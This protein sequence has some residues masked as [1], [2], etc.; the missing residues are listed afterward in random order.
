MRY[1]FGF[2]LLGILTPVFFVSAAEPI[3]KYGW[4][5]QATSY[6]E[7]AGPTCAEGLIK[8][9]F[10]LYDILSMNHISVA[11]VSVIAFNIETQATV[12][13]VTGTGPVTESV[14]YNP[15]TD[16]IA[17]YVEGGSDYFNFYS[18]KKWSEPGS[19]PRWG[20]ITS[21]VYLMPTSAPTPEYAQVSPVDTATSINPEYK[22]E[23][24][25]I[26]NLFG[27]T[28]FSDVFFFLNKYD[29]ADGSL[30]NIVQRHYAKDSGIGIMTIPSQTLSEGWYRWS[31]YLSLNAL[32]HFVPGLTMV[33]QPVSGWSTN[34]WPFLYDTT[35][36]EVQ[37]I[38]HTPAAVY[39][40]EQVQ[41]TGETSDALAG[42]KE[43]RMYFDGVFAQSCGYAS[44]Q[45]AQCQ[46]NVGPFPVGTTHSY[47]LV[48]TDGV[49]L[50]STS[51]VGTFT[52]L[53]RLLPN[54]LTTSVAPANG[55]S[56]SDS[57]PSIVFSGI[58]ESTN[59]RFA[60][61]GGWADLE[62]DWNSDGGIK[63]TGGDTFDANFNAFNGLMLGGFAFHEQKIL[64]YEVFNPPVGTHRYRFTA[65][66]T[67]QLPES[68]ENDNHS[69]WRT[70]I[71]EDSPNE[72]V[73]IPLTSA[74]SCSDVLPDDPIP[75]Q[76]INNCDDWTEPSMCIFEC[77]DG[78][79]KNVD[80][81]ELTECNDDID[82]TDAEDNHVD[83]EDVGCVDINDNDESDSLPVIT[84][85]VST[86][87]SV[88][89]VNAGDEV[90]LLWDTNNGDESLC[91]LVGPGID[92]DGVL[93]SEGDPETGSILV[94]IYGLSTYTL[95]CGGLSSQLKIEIA[96]KGW[97]S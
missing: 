66:V 58:A 3:G 17:I 13:T 51:T 88:S 83:M 16:G 52:V 80:V 35:P 14:C 86:L 24:T 27:A 10:E 20:L 97:N 37:S 63:G 15:D 79:V 46:L 89:V 84:S 29:P 59:V 49:G 77:M 7:L 40:T 92:G 9:A 71:V 76:L 4:M 53:E 33:N 48:S 34:S 57:D 90:S 75:Y 64:S 67:S 96:Q 31:Y 91:T 6:S 54:I 26:P 95:T 42:V 21:T 50:I 60:D 8:E 78:Y 41:I 85:S 93:P 43:I 28:L 39:E 72:C 23:T 5:S 45:T 68:D 44:V 61:Q 30:V 70:F 38:T 32:T 65:D 25:H 69:E 82:N 74:Q 11:E 1:T 87:N 56:V 55:Y 18:V 47:F 73:G 2:L 19:V 22:I 94:H 62:I 81:C 36:P 12:D